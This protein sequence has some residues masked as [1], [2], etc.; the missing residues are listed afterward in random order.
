M[1]LLLGRGLSVSRVAQDVLQRALRALGQR[2][3]FAFTSAQA[4]DSDG[5]YAARKKR[6]RRGSSGENRKYACLHLPVWHVM[7]MRALL[8]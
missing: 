1:L 2:S 6:W 4:K 3:L 5:A 7:Q 8:G